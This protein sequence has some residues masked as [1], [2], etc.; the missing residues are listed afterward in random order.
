MGSEIVRSQPAF[1][2]LTACCEQMFMEPYQQSG[3]RES[4]NEAELK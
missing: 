4:E 1:D 3:E 2:S